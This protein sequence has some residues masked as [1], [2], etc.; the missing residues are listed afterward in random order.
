MVN[1]AYARHL[2]LTGPRIGTPTVNAIDNLVFRYVTGE[3]ETIKNGQPKKITEDVAMVK[4]ADFFLDL[5][6]Q[7]T[8]RNGDQIIIASGP[9]DAPVSELVTVTVAF[10]AEG[11]ITGVTVG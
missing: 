11:V 5:A 9:E 7:G 6:M 2:V 3:Y 8:V 1:K 10:D 4:G